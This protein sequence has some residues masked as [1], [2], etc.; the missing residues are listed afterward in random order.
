MSIR[1]HDTDRLPDRLLDL[2]ADRELDGLA[3]GEA[4]ELD[5]LLS[6]HGEWTGDELGLA[7]AELCRLGLTTDEPV[8]SGI[9]EK[10]IGSGMA[11]LEGRAEG[12]RGS[13]AS[14]SPRILWLGRAGWLA[15]A[16]IFLIAVAASWPSRE[17]TVIDRRELLLARADDVVT[18]PW[19][20]IMELEPGSVT[21]DGVWSNREQEG[22][23]HFKG[24]PVNDPAREQYQL[25]IL[26]D[27][28]AHPVDGGVFDMPQV[29]EAIIP[30]AAKLRVSRPTAFAIT[31]EKPGGVVVSDRSRL[32]LLA[33]F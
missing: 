32:I 28:Q 6:R 25:W 4:T 30:V 8:P 12:A 18:S 20:V 3:K 33:S 11:F 17:P 7:A 13:L 10:L 26:D 21:G 5:G 23:L 31:V 16:V 15:A 24:L 14:S 27:E 29:S 22:Y 2:L 1:S 9:S 19:S